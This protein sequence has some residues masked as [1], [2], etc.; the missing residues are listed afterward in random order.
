MSEQG[1][2][3]EVAK[4]LAEALEDPTSGLLAL[5]KLGKKIRP[6]EEPLQ[7]HQL[8]TSLERFLVERHREEVAKLLYR[9]SQEGL[10]RIPLVEDQGHWKVVLSMDRCRRR[11]ERLRAE[12][13]GVEDLELL[14]RHF[15]TT[16]GFPPTPYELARASHALHPHWSSRLQVALCLRSEDRPR[17]ALVLVRHT[18]TSASNEQR[19]FEH[20]ARGAILHRLGKIAEA[21]DEYRQATRRTETRPFA[22]VC[23]LSNSILLADEPEARAASE[24]LEE[25]AP[26][27]VGEVGES[28]VV[29]RALIDERT[30]VPGAASVRLARRL[31]TKLPPTSIEILDILSQGQAWATPRWSRESRPRMGAGGH[32]GTPPASGDPPRRGRVIRA[33]LLK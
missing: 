16:S 28:K 14:D 6:S 18:S 5:P 2:S 31:R 29:L 17:E 20:T 9:A 10:M 24:S 12:R 7:P 32:G 8:D 26:W 22:A 4:L 3:P 21:R 33:S 30:I 19:F 27:D 11:R 23:W 25:V 1:F 13:A 15:G